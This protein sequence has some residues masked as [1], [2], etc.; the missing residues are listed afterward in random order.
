MMTSI[1]VHITSRS[2]SY[3]REVEN[4]VVAVPPNSYN[5]S[6]SKQ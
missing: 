4:G 3:K 2:E 1:D 5:E 6:V